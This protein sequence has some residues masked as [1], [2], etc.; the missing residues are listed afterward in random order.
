MS[1]KL[2]DRIATLVKADA[3]GV[4]ESL[5]DRSLLL[6]QCLREAEIDLSRKRAELEALHDEEKRLREMQARREGEARALDEDVTLA[7]AG[8]KDELARFA[9]RRLL[10][11]RSEAKAAS[12]RLQEL[13]ARSRT[14]A[15]RLTEQESQF[16]SL[17]TR[18]RAELAREPELGSPCGWQGEPV[19]ADEEVEL[20]LLRRRRVAE[21]GGS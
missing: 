4:V 17:R 1:L 13:A 11:R 20:E 9:I 3:H 8:G 12:A 14:L 2:F 5:E 19:V 7:L 16:E 21:G 15:E 6:K 18:V 10:P